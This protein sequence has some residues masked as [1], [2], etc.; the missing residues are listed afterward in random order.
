[1]VRDQKKPAD[2]FVRFPVWLELSQSQHDAFTWAGVLAVCTGHRPRTVE[3]MEAVRSLHRLIAGG[4]SAFLYL[5]IR[6]LANPPMDW[7]NPETLDNFLA[8]VRQEQFSFLL[9]QNKRSFGLFVQQMKMFFDYY[10]DAFTPFLAALPLLGLYPLWKSNRFL[11]GFVAGLALLLS[12]G[13]V[14]ALNYGTDRIAIV[15]NNVFFIPFAMMAA[16]FV[17]IG[18]AWIATLRIRAVSLK[19]A[20]LLLAVLC[21]VLPITV[22]Y[23]ANDK[24]NYWFAYDYGKNMLDTLEPNAIYLPAADHATFPIVYLQS[25]EGMRPDVTIGNKYGYPE[26]SLYQDMPEEV[27]QSFRSIPTDSE[28]RLIEEWVVSRSDRP[29]YFTEKRGFPPQLGVKLV[30]AGLAYRIVREDETW[31]SPDYWSQY[32]WHS[33]KPADTYG[34]FTAEMVLSDYHFAHGRDL[35]A[36]GELAQAEEHFEQSAS[37]SA[38]AS[39]ELNN[40]GTA[41]AENGHVDAAA[42]Y[43]FRS[44]ESDPNYKTGLRN[45]G[46]IYMTL[47]KYEAARL[48]FDRLKSLEPKNPFASLQ[49]ASALTALGRYTDAEEELKAFIDTRP[50]DPRGHREL[51]L[52]YTKNMRERA[53]GREHIIRSLELDPNQSDLREIINDPKL[54]HPQMPVLPNFGRFENQIPRI[55]SVSP[56]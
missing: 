12:I 5:P 19:P 53:R 15:V 43:Y 1:M 45:L 39:E 40:I 11:F 36:K 32:A 7:G 46:Q 29:V 3:A 33:L 2:S 20:K 42:K 24:S 4:L 38:Q 35:L 52:L 13:L 34:E 17:G 56:K 54:L 37:I 22:H 31:Q 50:N 9:T 49:L 18:I 14:L 44:I 27:R 26:A 21:V 55:P 30:N 8:V 48:V 41:L 25:V 23:R 28:Q 6:S 16:I 10:V 51:G 47:E